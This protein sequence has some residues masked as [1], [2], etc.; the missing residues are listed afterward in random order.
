MR[1]L[2]NLKLNDDSV[3]CSLPGLQV[4]YKVFQYVRYFRDGNLVYDILEQYR[5]DVS[6]VNNDYYIVAADFITQLVEK[7]QTV[8]KVLDSFAEKTGKKPFTKNGLKLVKITTKGNIP[9]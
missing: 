8:T 3:D 7:E 4:S 6:K 9:F 1:E 5:S 2:V